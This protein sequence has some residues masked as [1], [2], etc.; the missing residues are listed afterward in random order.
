MDEKDR[1]VGGLTE[2]EFALFEDGI[3]QELSFFTGDALPLSVSLLVDCS[4][5]MEQKLGTAQEAGARFVR[6]LGAR[7]L[8]QVVQFND[9]VQVLQD[10][11]SDQAA[12]DVAL[13]STRATGATVLYNAL[14][15]T[16]KDLRATRAAALTRPG[17]SR[18][19]APER[20][21]GHGL[22]WPRRTRCWP[23]PAR[24]GSRSTRS[25][26]AS[27]RRRA[28]ARGRGPRQVLPHHR[29][30]RDGRRGVLSPPALSDLDAVYSRIA[31][32][33]RSQYT[34]GYVSS[35]G[36]RDGRWR[37]IVVRTPDRI[38]LHSRYAGRLLRKPMSDIAS[39]PA[40]AQSASAS[41]TASWASARTSP[42]LPPPDTAELLNQLTRQEA[43]AVLSPAGGAARDRGAATSPRCAAAAR[44]SSSSSRGARPR[45]LE[46]LSADQRTEIV[47]GMGDYRAP[48]AADPRC[49]SRGAR[50]S[51][52][53]LLHYP[54]PRRG[55][56][57]DHRV[58]PPGA[59]R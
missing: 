49:P 2:K 19:R 40:R 58:R 7:D 53:R 30:P 59:D 46:G 23:R 32:D 52:K 42:E 8:G 35:N 34:L 50:R 41:T 25:A 39:G 17:P 36:G 3:R 6:T 57:H 9:R 4:A 5:S 11:T 20:R 21:G 55:R 28:R 1:R 31:A 22:R 16:L 43:A 13:R 12:L 26:C 56:H 24:P 48:A 51:R 37:R 54:A 45:S 44:S 27:R 38:D 18:D 29:R 15:V 33:L 47:R 10:F 14:H